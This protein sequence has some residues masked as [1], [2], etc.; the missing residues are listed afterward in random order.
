MGK[1]KAKSFRLTQEQLDQINAVSSEADVNEEVLTSMLSFFKYAQERFDRRFSDILP[2]GDKK[3]WD[4]DFDP[5]DPEDVERIIKKYNARV[6]LDPPDSICYGW[7]VYD[8][9]G[10]MD[11]GGPNDPEP[12]AR[13]CGAL[14]LWLWWEKGLQCDVARDLARSHFDPRIGRKPD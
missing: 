12:L 4:Q 2:F 8:S 5:T 10:S 3:G 9:A 13:A 6:E 7:S 11:C 14:Y 1:D